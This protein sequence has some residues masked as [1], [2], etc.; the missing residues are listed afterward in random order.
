MLDGV[1]WWALGAEISRTYTWP[2]GS[3]YA[4]DGGRLLYQSEPGLH[5]VQTA[6]GAL[7]HIAP[8]WLAVTTV[9]SKVKRK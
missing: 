5:I 2:D 8:G 3:E 9:G 7:H 6:C 1:E 4:V